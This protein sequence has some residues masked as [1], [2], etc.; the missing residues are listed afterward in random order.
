MAVARSRTGRFLLP[1]DLGEWQ[2]K[3]L[4]GYALVRFGRDYAP[5][6]L[7][8]SGNVGARLVKLDE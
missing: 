1:N 6:T 4:A 7:G 8:F 2:T 3:T 5:G